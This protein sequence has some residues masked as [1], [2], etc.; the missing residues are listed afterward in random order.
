[1]SLKSITV[2]TFCLFLTS[3]IQVTV[4]G[5]GIGGL[6]AT[7]GCLLAGHDVDVLEAADQFGE[8][9]AGIQLLPNGSRILYRWGLR[10]IVRKLAIR[11]GKVNMWGWKGNLISSLDYHDAAAQ[12]PGS[13]F[14]DF[15]RPVL[16]KILLDRAIELGAKLHN[17]C[18]VVDVQCHADGSGANVV[19][20]DGSV[21]A[22][23]LVVGADG[24]FGNLREI[25]L[26]RPDP[27]IR[28]GDMAYRI[29][30]PA[31]KLLDD[32]ELA[33]FIKEPQVNYWLGPDAHC[34]NYVLRG[35]ELFNF[36][37]ALKD[38]IPLDQPNRVPGDVNVMRE[39]FKDWEPR[40]TKLLSKCE[41][42]EK[43]RLCY[44]LGLDSWNDPSGSFTMLGDAVHATVPYFASGYE[45]CIR[46]VKLEWS[47][48]LT[49][50]LVPAFAS[51][52]EPCSANV[53]H[54]SSPSRRRKNN[55]HSLS[56]NRVA[57]IVQSCWSD[58]GT[59]SKC[60]ITSP[61]G[62]SRWSETKR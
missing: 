55:T 14:L 26:K 35:G 51:K 53:Y 10:E 5:G 42:V 18:R 56:M 52:T 45:L 33:V 3:T 21:R 38:D 1:M 46:L 25:M 43:W 48:R 59:S 2:V 12:Y 19:L 34:V 39:Y 28:S 13:D 23:D 54:E 15:H 49:P 20:A 17:S 47:P 57:K 6:G 9:G 7:I 27:P 31:A 32:P 24:V 37:L 40:I 4:V 58:G 44:R 61:M 41:S 22:T 11:P 8:I 62:P 50:T 60:F 36:P 16:H 29:T 30:L